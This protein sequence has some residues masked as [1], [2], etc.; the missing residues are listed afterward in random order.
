MSSSLSS[1]C[2]GSG[3]PSDLWCCLHFKKSRFFTLWRL[4]YYLRMIFLLPECQ[5]IVQDCVP[6]I[7]EIIFRPNSIKITFY[8]PRKN[9]KTLVTAS[10]IPTLWKIFI[11]SVSIFMRMPQFSHYLEQVITILY[12]H[13]FCTTKILIS[14]VNTSE[15]PGSES[16][17]ALCILYL[18]FVVSSQDKMFQFFNLQ[19]IWV[20][21]S[22]NKDPWLYLL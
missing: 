22:T 17:E 7:A 20:W 5:K 18:W 21:E 16:S 9:H 8:Y 4:I 12:C 14:S 19:G 10:C 13:S 6:E 11:T 1:S 3:S 2:S 15:V